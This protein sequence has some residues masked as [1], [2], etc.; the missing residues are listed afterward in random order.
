MDEIAGTLVL[1]PYVF[2]FLVAYLALAWRDLGPRGAAGLLA[3]G[4]AV[5]FAAEYA[6]T[7]IG[8]P[9]GLYHYTGQTRGAE[10]YVSNVPFFDSLSFPFLAYAAWC[11]ARW[12]WPGAS[13]ARSVAAAGV[14]MMLLD[15][16]IDPAAVRGDRWFLGRIFY[17]PEGGAYFG[18]PLSNFLGWVVV[19]WAILGG[20]AVATG[21]RAPRG[22]PR[23]GVLL[24]YGILLFNLGVTLWICEWW[25]LAAGILLHIVAFL[26]LCSVGGDLGTAAALRRRPVSGDVSRP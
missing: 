12:A 6:S 17:Y 19:G 15:L 13:P 4:F 20:Y 26:L 3:W 2:G 9:F 7:R 5:A 23:P 18:V 11:A 22:S 25:L 14:L 21:G 1:R 24:Y 8:V 16:V 10:L